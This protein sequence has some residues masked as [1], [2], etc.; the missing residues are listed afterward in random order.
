MEVLMGKSSIH[1]P[2]SM[3][4]LN[5]QRVHATTCTNQPSFTFETVVATWRGTPAM[6]TAILPV[7]WHPAVCCCSSWESCGPL[8]KGQNG[9]PIA[10]HWVLDI[11]NPQNEYCNGFRNFQIPTA[12]IF[13]EFCSFLQ[14]YRFHIPPRRWTSFYRVPCRCAMH[15]LWC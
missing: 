9:K 3:A 14:L 7:V 13:D 2:F 5:N 12:T 11:V 8:A 1:G 10:Q 15:V 4:M 6:W